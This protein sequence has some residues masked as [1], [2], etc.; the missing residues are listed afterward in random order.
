[1][2]V[3]NPIGLVLLASALLVLCGC[4][5]GSPSAASFASD[6]RVGK[7]GRNR[8]VTP[9]NQILTPAGLQVELPGMRPQVLALSPD[10]RILI[11]SGKTSELVVIDPTVGRVIQR[12]AL[13]SETNS[14]SEPDAVSPNILEPDK[15]GQVS[16]TGLVFS[17][18]GRRVYLANV[19]GSVKVFG[20]DDE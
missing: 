15:D 8:Y 12:V 20:V 7:A 9:A 3:W 16:F 19:N 6:E 18:H 4:R 5:S 2:K 1:M 14:V 10:G 17:P 13:P 11:T